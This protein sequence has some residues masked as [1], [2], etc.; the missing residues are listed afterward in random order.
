MVLL[1]LHSE[2]REGFDPDERPEH[3]VGSELARED[4]EPAHQARAGENP[5]LEAAQWC[6]AGAEEAENQLRTAAC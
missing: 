2:S 6:A 5:F 4:L 1:H 3:P